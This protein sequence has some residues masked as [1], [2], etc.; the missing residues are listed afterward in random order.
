MSALRAILRRVRRVHSHESPTGPC[1]L[2]GQQVCELTPGGVVDTL[3]KTMVMRHPVDRQ[4]FHCDQV[5]LVHDAAAVLL[6][7]VAAAPRAALVDPGHHLAP[8]GALQRALLGLAQAT[9]R[10]SE[11]LLLM[12]EEAWIGNRLL[13]A[14]HG[15]RLQP[16]VHTHLLPRLRQ[17]RGFSTLARKSDVPF[18]GTAAPNG[19]G[20]GRAL[21]GPMIDELDASD[22]HGVDALCT[23][24]QL[25]ADRHLGKRDAVVAAHAAKARIAGRVA[26]SAAAEERLEGQINAHGHILQDPRLHARQTGPLRFESGQ[27]SVLVIQAH[28]LLAL[29]PRIAALGQQMV[30]QPAAFL[31]LLLQASLLRGCRVE[32][33]REGLTHF[34]VVA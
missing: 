16:H 34:P 2:V 7:E 24:F 32:S 28:R 11:R 29:L 10:L 22:V 30:V 31:K 26:S 4:V 9:L 19:G 23:R 17:W 25:A 6:G 14:E 5:K 33:V 13:R 20:L 3:G 21:D 8:L 18:A 15:E 1:C 27:R 12:A